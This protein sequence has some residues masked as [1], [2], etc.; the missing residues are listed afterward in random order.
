M[1]F[2]GRYF[3]SEERLLENNFILKFFIFNL[4]FEN[5]ISLVLDF[6]SCPK[7]CRVNLTDSFDLIRRISRKRGDTLGDVFQKSTKTF[8]KASTVTLEPTKVNVP[9]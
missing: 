4:Y 1:I 2:V 8:V 9:S 7:I 5:T 6:Q 3:A